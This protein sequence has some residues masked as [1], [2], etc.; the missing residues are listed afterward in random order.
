LEADLAHHVLQILGDPQLGRRLGD[1][2][3]RSVSERYSLDRVVATLEALYHTLPEPSSRSVI[4]PDLSAADHDRYLSL[5][6]RMLGPEGRRTGA[7]V[8]RQWKA[9]IESRCLAC[10]RGRLARE[11]LALLA[12]SASENRKSDDVRGREWP[13]ELERTV[14]AACPLGLLQRLVVNPRKIAGDHRAEP[15]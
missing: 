8:W 2:A 15:V 14:E 13:D 4:A 5:L 9:D 12:L 1:N 6:E 3:R 10:N 11:G 7:V